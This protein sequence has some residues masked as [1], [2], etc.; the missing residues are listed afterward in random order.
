HENGIIALDITDTSGGAVS[1]SNSN[2]VNYQNTEIFFAL[3]MD[4]AGYR[5]NINGTNVFSGAQANKTYPF[6]AETWNLF[7]LTCEVGRFA[8][9]PGVAMDFTDSDVRDLFYVDGVAQDP[10]LSWAEFGEPAVDLYGADQA[11]QAVDNTS[12]ENDFTLV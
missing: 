1:N 3:T 10:A 4:A 7:A 2:A 8:F 5:V 11:A 12:N 9:W 6:A